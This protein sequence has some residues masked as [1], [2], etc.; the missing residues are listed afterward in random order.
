MNTRR[1]IVIRLLLAVATLSTLALAAGLA[2]SRGASG[3]TTLHFLLRESATPRDEGA[4]GPSDFERVLY[5][6][7]LLDP[8]TRKAVGH[9]LGVCTLVDARTDMRMVCQLV[10]TPG[11]RQGLSFADQI[12]ATTVFDDVP[13]SKPQLSAITGGTGRYAGVRGQI[14]AKEAPGGLVDLT[15]QLTR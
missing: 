6:G 14:L 1:R 7:A 8:K 9:E 3:A 5:K 11:A 12:S 10:F 2:T 15:F 4:K 13:S